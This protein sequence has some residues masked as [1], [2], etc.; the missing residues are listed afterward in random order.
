MY[1][2]SWTVSRSRLNLT[3]YISW[4]MS[5]HNSLTSIRRL[6]LLKHPPTRT[7]MNTSRDKSV[8]KYWVSK[9]DSNNFPKFRNIK[10]FIDPMVLC[11]LRSIEVWN[12]PKMREDYTISTNPLCCVDYLCIMSPLNECHMDSK[13]VN[14]CKDH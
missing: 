14:E 11:G 8:E 6:A 4:V 2:N 10:L 7:D 1:H 3:K 13:R 5:H 12:L 9:N